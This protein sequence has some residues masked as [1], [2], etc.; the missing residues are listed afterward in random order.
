[1]VEEFAKICK[2]KGINHFHLITAAFSNPNSLFL[3]YQTK[4][5][6]EEAVKKLGFPRTS[7]YRPG[8]IDPGNEP[9]SVEK[10]LA[11]FISGIKTSIFARAMI[12][13]AIQQAHDQ[14]FNL[15]DIFSDAQIRSIGS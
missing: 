10:F 4:G 12:K 5:K 15:L 3:Y 6:A 13:V 11:I 7:I 14:K 9:R 8:L 2:E 1:L